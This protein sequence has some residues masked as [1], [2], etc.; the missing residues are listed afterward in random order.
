M[1]RLLFRVLAV[2]GVLTVALVASG[3]WMWSNASKSNVGELSFANELRIPPLAEPSLSEP[4]RK[5]FDL[6]LE[7]GE[8]ELLPGKPADTWGV[9]GP[10]LGSTLRAERGDDVRINVD[11]ELPETTALYWHGMHLPATADGGPHQ[12]IEPRVSESGDTL[13][14]PERFVELGIEVG[15]LVHGP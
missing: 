7:Q 5:V 14:I 4:G 11:N 10:Y 3:V 6:R 12:M 2:L 9:N 15:R 8:A 13:V 1:R